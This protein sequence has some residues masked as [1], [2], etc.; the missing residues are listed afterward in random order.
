MKESFSIS[1]DICYNILPEGFMKKEILEMIKKD[2]SDMKKIANG[3]YSEIL[4][5]EK[6][7]VVERYRYL[8]SLKESKDLKEYGEKCIVSKI[9]D[10]YGHGAIKETN[11]IWCFLFEAAENYSKG[12]EENITM[13]VYRNI[14]DGSKII[15]I[16]KGSREEFEE[17]HNVVFGKSQIEDY[18]DRYNNVKYEFFNDCITDG[19]E[20]AVKKLFLRNS[21]KERNF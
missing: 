19:Q 11:D 4:E 20:V 9:M 10:K 1:T 5:L 7:P 12:N 17:T 21:K 2:Y 14:E 15:A 6:N 16:S 13:A 3:D 8:V 18:S